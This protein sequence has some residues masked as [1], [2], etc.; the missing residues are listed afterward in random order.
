MLLVCRFGR[1]YILWYTL[2]LL[3]REQWI[4]ILET[5]WYPTKIWINMAHHQRNPL[6]H[7]DIIL[8]SAQIHKFRLDIGVVS[9]IILYLPMHICTLHCQYKMSSLFSGY[10]ILRSISLK[11][12]S[13]KISNPLPLPQIMWNTPR[14]TKPQSSIGSAHEFGSV[15]SREMPAESG[16]NKST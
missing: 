12:T 10:S 15:M 6:V 4:K 8:K 13:T 2:T 1:C 11:I 14:W 9:K 16:C 7:G 5:P 3:A